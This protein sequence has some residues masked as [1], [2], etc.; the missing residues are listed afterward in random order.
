VSVWRLTVR[1]TYSTSPP[2]LDGDRANGEIM[3]TIGFDKLPADIKPLAADAA[4]VEAQKFESEGAQNR[5]NVDL[6]EISPYVAKQ[7]VSENGG[8]PW[9]RGK[10]YNVSVDKFAARMDRL[11][12]YMTTNGITCIAMPPRSALQAIMLE[13]K[14]L[15][16]VAT[17]ASFAT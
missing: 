13:S 8:L 5:T 7:H 2:T 9:M 10:P 15:I 12:S 16:A 6:E 14:G 3:A 1:H 4:Y 17:E 11:E